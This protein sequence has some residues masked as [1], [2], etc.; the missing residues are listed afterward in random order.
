MTIRLPTPKLVYKEEQQTREQLIA[1]RQRLLDEKVV[2]DREIA[3]IRTQL[4]DAVAVSIRGPEWLRKATATL[5]RKSQRSQWIQAELGSLRRRIS[6]AN[7]AID[8]VDRVQRDKDDARR[9]VSASRKVLDR[10]TYLRIWAL[11]NEV[12]LDEGGGHDDH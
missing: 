12:E 7:L 5:R 1:E 10:E 3:S 9:F 8:A 6:A 2:N 4:D 11:A